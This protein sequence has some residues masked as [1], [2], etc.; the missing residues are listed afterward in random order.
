MLPVR[1]LESRLTW[2][3]RV[4]KRNVVSALESLN[5]SELEVHH[6]QADVAVRRRSERPRDS[7]DLET[8]P[9]PEV[10]RGGV[11]LDDRVELDAVEA[12]VAVP[13]WSP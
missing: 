3:V 13:M 4:K 6:V 11:E 7:A 1:P 12:A 2:N 5:Y 8:Q 10:H 9:P